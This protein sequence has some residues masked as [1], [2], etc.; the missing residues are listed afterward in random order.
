[1]S[2]E[3]KVTGRTSP[4]DGAIYSLFKMRVNDYFPK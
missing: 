3:E 4:A 1:M 2:F